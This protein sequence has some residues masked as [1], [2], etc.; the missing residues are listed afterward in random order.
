MKSATSE[1]VQFSPDISRLAEEIGTSRATVMNY[2]NYLQEARLINMVYRE[3]EVV[4]KKPAAVYLHDGNLIS[5]VCPRDS[6]EQLLMETFFVNSLWRH[7]SVKKA[8]RDGQFNVNGR[9]NI[10]VC[11]KNKRIKP[12]ADTI[13]AKYNTEVGQGNDIPLWLFGFLY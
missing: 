12:V 1:F 5:A 13:Y 10:C 7:H 3:G 11:D 6:R 4:P 8:R 9:I 2:L